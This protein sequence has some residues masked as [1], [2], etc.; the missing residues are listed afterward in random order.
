MNLRFDHLSVWLF[1]RSYWSSSDSGNPIRSDWST[2]KAKPQT[3][4][5]DNINSGMSDGRGRSATPGSWEAGFDTPL[6][7]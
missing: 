2:R 7:I 3:S 5:S 6:P 1:R 4:A